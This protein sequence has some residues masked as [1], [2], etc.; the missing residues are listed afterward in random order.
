MKILCCTRIFFQTGFFVQVDALDSECES[1]RLLWSERLTIVIWVR[2]FGVGCSYMLY[3]RRVNAMLAKRPVAAAT[4]TT[5]IYYCC[6][7]LWLLLLFIC[8]DCFS[9]FVSFAYFPNHSHTLRSDPCM[10]ACDPASTLI[11]HEHIKSSSDSKGNGN[12]IACL[13]WLNSEESIVSPAAVLL[14]VFFPLS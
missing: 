4:S 9:C 3:N 13:T 10:Y 1:K 7:C 8:F 5:T 12:A 11:S 2:L 14:W 6:Y